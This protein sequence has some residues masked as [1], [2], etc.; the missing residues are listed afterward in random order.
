MLD[1]VAKDPALEPVSELEIADEALV[2][3]YRATRD[4]KLFEQLLKR[5]EREIFTFLKRF[6]LD[7]QLAEDTFQATFLSVHLRIDQFDESRKFR[8]WL[9]A[10]ATNKAIDAQRRNKR[11]RLKSIDAGSEYSVDD[12][13][14]IA[15]HWIGRSLDPVDEAMN[16]ESKMRVQ[17]ALRELSEPTQNLIQMA[18]YQ[19]M[20]YSD[21]GEILGIPVGTVKSR[22]HTA[23]KRLQ[24]VWKR[25]YGDSPGV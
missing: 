20:K 18:I 11:H 3:A 7:S 17:T 25:L 22:V 19:G 10:I 13:D 1:G 12:R 4:R 14:S 24:E 2:R 15:T 23:M 8:P 21:I 5:Y 6:L 16:H 9:Y